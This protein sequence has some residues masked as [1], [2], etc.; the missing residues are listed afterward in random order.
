MSG[1]WQELGTRLE[2]E[3]PLADLDSSSSMTRVV[4]L[5]L[6][7]LSLASMAGRIGGISSRERTPMVSA[8][9]R[10]RWSTVRAL[11]DDGQY[12]IDRL[13]FVYDDEGN[14]RLRSDGRP[15]RVREWQTIDLV[16]HRGKDGKQHY[17]SSKPPLLPTMIAGGY[18]IIQR[19]LGLEM[20]DNYSPIIRM[21]LIFVNVLPMALMFWLTWKLVERYCQSDWGRVFVMA[22]ASWG[23]FLPTFAVVLNNHLPGAISTMV[24]IYA[25]FQ[26]MSRDQASW[27]WYATAGLAAGFAAANE[28]PALS[29]V[30]A[31]AVGLVWKS[32]LK[33][34]AY[35]AM[36][37][38]VAAA[39]FGTNLIAHGSWRPPYMHRSDGEKITE[40][41]ADELQQGPAPIALRETMAKA[42][43]E[44]S[45]EATVYTPET[46]ERWQVFDPET[47]RR[48]ALRLGDNG[49]CDVHVW[50]DWYD[51]RFTVWRGNEKKGVDRGEPSVLRY[52][53]HVLIGHHG[54]FSLTPVWIMSLFGVIYVLRYGEGEFRG[55]ALLTATLT[56]VCTT[57][58][59]LRPME[60]RNYGGVSCGFRWLYWQIP[61]W[62][63][64]LIPAADWF[65][66][67]PRLRQLALAMLVISAGS[68]AY[69]AANPFSHPWLYD[70][71]VQ[72]GWA[73]ND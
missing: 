49:F 14:V 72:M 68:A 29:L 37:A 64:A 35:F 17:Y 8:N 9:D 28:L 18:W 12:A 1:D 55:F 62:T 45:D 34:L 21:L 11:V 50:D 43:V 67:R 25:V 56:V 42:G 47:E 66:E 5:M 58:Y 36:V 26:I 30:A 32:P 40:F 31:L 70:F 44:L 54:I 52:T 22:V 53:A 10:S 46:W 23:T 13:V 60:D 57:F 73:S 27:A 24:A 7:L 33:S 59:L 3:S 63:I 16:Q 2:G 65:A 71:W 38:V 69:G 6:T 4:C 48:W 39:F 20:E 51:Y 15:L 19:T 61:M 41:K